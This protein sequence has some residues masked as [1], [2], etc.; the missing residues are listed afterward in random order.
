MP[1]RAAAASVLTRNCCMVCAAGKQWLSFA[2][3][4]QGM[5]VLV[6]SVP[7]SAVLRYSRWC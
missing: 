3:L 4:K 5:A 1:Y 7:S 2:P 6:G